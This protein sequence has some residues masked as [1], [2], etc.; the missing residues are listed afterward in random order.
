MNSKTSLALIGACAAF[1]IGLVWFMVQIVS[2]WE[3]GAAENAA[4]REAAEIA[5]E[6]V[7]P[8]IGRA[9]E[10]ASAASAAAEKAAAAA[11]EA[12]GV[13]RDAT[14]KAAAE[15]A[16]QMADEAV[17]AVVRDQE[18]KAAEKAA[19]EALSAVRARAKTASYEQAR[20]D[21]L[22]F[23]PAIDDARDEQCLVC[24]SEIL[25][26]QVNEQSPAGVRA[27]E[28]LAWYQTLDTYA[29]DQQTFHQRHITSDYAREVMNLSCN[30]CHKGNDPREEAAQIPHAQGETQLAATGPDGDMPAFTLRKMVNPSDT[31]LR[32]HGSFPWENMEGLA[33]PWHEIRADFEFEPGENGCLTCHGDLF[34][35]VRHQVTYLHADRIEELAQ[36]SS[37]VCYG[38][39]GGR[40]WYRISYPFPRTPWPDMPEETPEW[41]TG[42]ATASDV[43]Q[44]ARPGLT[45]RRNTTHGYRQTFQHG[46]PALPAVG[47]RRKRRRRACTDGIAEKCE[48]IRLRA[49]SRR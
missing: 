36:E 15:I 47:C 41:A 23:S 11:E 26:R 3:V 48:S 14:E 21:P 20:W 7:L 25:D 2:H 49:L 38:C 28:S 8:V 45:K 4:R 10:A 31:C 5:R 34:R 32:C 22:H 9:E 30:F 46:S 27:D 17:R 42:R 1:V 12:A 18:R 13:A 37:D 40:A 43:R 16:R 19:A 39:H 29:G 44:Q 6:A 35:T 24:H 33:G